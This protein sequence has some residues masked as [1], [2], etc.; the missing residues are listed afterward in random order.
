[1]PELREPDQEDEKPRPRTTAEPEASRADEDAAASGERAT[2]PPPP[3]EEQRR[4]WLERVRDDPTHA[5]RAA[6]RAQRRASPG[7]GAFAW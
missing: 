5:L 4:R 1:M 2:A 3:D 6:A 7:R